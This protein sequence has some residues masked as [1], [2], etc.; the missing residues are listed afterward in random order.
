[1]HALAEHAP[2]IG[3]EL[4]VV[5]RAAARTPGPPWPFLLHVTT[6]A[7]DAK[8]VFGDGHAGDPD[9]LMH[10]VVCRAAAVVIR[11]PDPRSLIGEIG[12]A[13]VLGYLRAELRW[14]L[15]HAPEAYGV[16][17]AC[18]ALAYLENSSVVSKIEG[19]QYAIDRGGPVDLI[20][21]SLSMQQVTSADR[22]PSREAREFIDGVV[23]QLAARER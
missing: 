6:A 3:V 1:M 20:N 5:T 18:R 11:G 17:N 2:G 7:S 12:R 15:E 16:L 19:A 23:Q 8:T 4:S 13:H 22:P 14:A 21:E 10:Y 9:L